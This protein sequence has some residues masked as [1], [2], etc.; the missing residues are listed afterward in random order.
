M[1][2]KTNYYFVSPLA[3]IGT[4]IPALT[5]KSK[6]KIV[7]GSFVEIPLGKSNC[8]GI[9]LSVA[10]QPTFITKSIKTIL[11]IPPLPRHLLTLA[12]WIKQYYATGFRQVWQTFLPSGLT[13]SRRV[14][15]PQP[16]TS[17]IHDVKV[18]LTIDQRQAIKAIERNP[19]KACL[20]FGTAGSGKTEV[21]I[22]LAKRS[23]ARGKS[24]I[25]LVPEIALTTPMVDRLNQIFSEKIIINHSAL[26]E[27]QRHQN[28]LKI[29]E[30]Q[31]TKVVVGPRSSLFLP[32]R[33]LGL[34]VVDECHESSYKQDQAPRYNAIEVAGQLATLTGAKL[35][36][37]SA[38]PK[39]TEI[40]SA[41]HKVIDLAKLPK[42][43]SSTTKV[44]SEIIDLK[45]QTLFRRSRFLSEPLLNTLAETFRQKH[46][47][48]L[49]I[50]RR[51]SASSQLC[52]SCGYVLAC[53]NCR[54]SLTLHADT[55][56]LVCHWCNF[57]Q[58]P[59]AICPNCQKS[60]WRFIGGGTKKI[61]AEIV[62]LFPAAKILR[63]DRD[64]F[65]AKT[66]TQTYRD[67]YS[68]QIDI[69]IGTQMIAKGFDLPLLDTVGIV[70][71]D[72]MLYLPD[73]SASE[74]TFQLLLQAS[75]RAGRRNNP[76][77]VFIQTFTPK[78]PVIVAAANNDYDAFY[79]NEIANRRLLGYPPFSYLL[80]LT[81][82]K[83]SAN[84]ASKA[85]FSLVNQLVTNH[86]IE[87]LG[88]APSF[89]EY[90]N[91]KY[92]WQIIIKSKNRDSLL[93]IAQKLPTGWT[94]D[95]DPVNLL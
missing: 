42:S 24:V 38:T 22:E 16:T 2:H 50:N 8:L 72:T 51:G 21:Y 93:T 75:G 86:Q 29:L 53:P 82:A 70:S 35:V 58:T 90:R 71:A 80:K 92:Y 44:R 18:K 62:R 81:C 39:I 85:A 73:Y 78:H 13:K 12:D 60:T 30:S 69:I 52:S 43:I 23:L 57:Q 77:K 31:N 67:L 19:H 40:Y 61:E 25:I 76:S 94:S 55:L 83:N 95:L 63:I 7:N 64:S 9:V 34:I 79:N 91:R 32:I 88:P 36:L 89:Y 11:N 5:Y 66:M 68:G 49:F 41:K 65:I 10:P 37:G 54:L 84:L 59:P 14:K 15:V 4:K 56:R 1:P 48:L 47:S 87:V 6:Q 46:Q 26:S 27:S 45:N 3:G 28:W 17:F 74:R 33:K 20:L